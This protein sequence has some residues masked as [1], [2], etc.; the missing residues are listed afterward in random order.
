MESA[1]PYPHTPIGSDCSAR[2][3]VSEGRVKVFDLAGARVDLDDLTIPVRRNPEIRISPNIPIG[4]RQP[5]RIL[6]RGRQVNGVAAVPVQ[7]IVEDDSEA[8]LT[9]G[10]AVVDNP[11]V[12]EAVAIVINL[13]TLLEW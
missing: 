7:R 9:A 8:T 2:G 5:V 10:A 3:A 13:V 12:G 4:Q 11:F 1:I 6:L